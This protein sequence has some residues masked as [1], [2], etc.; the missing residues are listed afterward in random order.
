M[1]HKN[2]KELKEASI[3]SYDYMMSF[4]KDTE[5]FFLAANC[6]DRVLEMIDII[7]EAQDL[8]DYDDALG[9]LEEHRCEGIDF[10]DAL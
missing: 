9:I 8:I 10:G 5:D 3:E 2:L 7:Q 1:N 6:Y 4:E